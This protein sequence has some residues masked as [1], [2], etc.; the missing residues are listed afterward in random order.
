MEDGSARTLVAAARTAAAS[1]ALLALDRPKGPGNPQ[2]VPRPPRKVDE[3][4]AWERSKLQEWWNAYWH[5]QQIFFTDQP[6]AA[7]VVGDDELLTSAGNLHGG[8]LGGRVLLPAA[9]PVAATVVAVHRD[10]DLAL[11]RSE[12]PLGLPPVRFAPA[13]ATG[14]AVAII[15]RHAAEAPWTLTTGIV[16]AR[17]RR[18]GQSPQA[19]VQTDAR[20]NYGSLG[21]ALVDAQG[22]VVG[23]VVRLGPD[24]RFPWLINSGVAVAVDADAIVEALSGLRQGRS[25]EEPQT[26]G[27]GIV[28]R[29]NPAGRVV[30]GAVKPGTGAAEAGLQPGDVIERAAGQRVADHMTL[31]KLLMRHRA[32]QELSLAVRR[33]DRVLTVSVKL[34]VF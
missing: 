11:L 3:A 17:G 27:L 19:L 21:G 22:A 26:L 32:G 28:L 33:G 2:P 7:L 20:A 18:S 13:P 12:R 4:P 6:V 34:S 24:D 15:G 5:Q 30:V 31:T 29:P 9:A 8:T 16:S 23:L 14:G 10:R 1:V 25:V